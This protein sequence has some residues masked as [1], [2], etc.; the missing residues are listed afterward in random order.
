MGNILVSLS[1]Y[2]YRYNES[3]VIDTVLP[4]AA[5]KLKDKLVLKSSWGDFQNSEIIELS[6]NSSYYSSIAT[7]TLTFVDRIYGFGKDNN[8]N[9]FCIN[10]LFD[11]NNTNIGQSGVVDSIAPASAELRGILELYHLVMY[12]LYLVS[13]TLIVLA[14]TSLIQY[15]GKASLILNN[16]FSDGYELY[17]T[18]YIYLHAL[19][20]NS[21]D[22]N[23]RSDYV[24]LLFTEYLDSVGENISS[25]KKY[26][27]AAEGTVYW[28]YHS[29][30]EFVWTIIPC[31]ALLFISLPSFTLALAL[32]EA[33]KPSDWVKVIGNQWFWVYEY[34]TYEGDIVIF[35]NIVQGDELSSSSNNSRALRMLE[36]DNSITIRANKFTRF[37]I[38]STDV[39]HSW[40]VP[41]LGVKVDACPGRIAT[42]TILPTRLGVYYGQCSEICGVNHGFMPICVEVVA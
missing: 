40:A 32:D 7:S 33:H 2:L 38:T 41:A 6:N 34:S 25:F 18:A 36:V 22:I 17:R 35:S 16:K 15:S 9:Y 24:E 13:F 10:S 12:I 5:R 30:I 27:V 23:E 1:A 4:K 28:V 31:L 37:L 11:I 19:N 20:N 8:S 42:V 39:I 29:Y 14:T 3:G 26:I 21:N